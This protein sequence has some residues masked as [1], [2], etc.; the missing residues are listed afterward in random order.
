MATFT[1]PKNLNGAEL[2]E[3]LKAAA[4]E[5]S[6]LSSAVSID[7]NGNLVLEIAAKDKTKAEAIVLAHNGTMVAPEPTIHQKL[8][9]VGLSIDELKV[10]LGV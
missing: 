10:A 3:E 8:E 4:I 5:I 1:L 2:R 9:S 7:E 6:D